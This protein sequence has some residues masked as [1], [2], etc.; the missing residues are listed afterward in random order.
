MIPDS[1][2]NRNYKR[3][4]YESSLLFQLSQALNSSRELSTIIDPVLTSMAENIAL[5]RGTVTI[6]SRITGK[7]SI[8]A[9]VELSRDEIKRGIYELGE[10]ITGKVVQSGRA[11]IIKNI[12]L[13]PLFLNKTGVRQRRKNSSFLCVPIKHDTETIGA[14]SADRIFQDEHGLTDDVQLLAIVASMISRTVKQRQSIEDK[15]KELNGKNKRLNES[16]E[17]EFNPFNMI[18]RSHSMQEAFSL[19]A[20][21]SRS[22]A[23]VFIRGESG[24]GKELVAQT[25][26]YNSLRAGKPFI[27]INCSALPESIIESELF[28]HEKGSFTGAVGSR[29]GRFELADGGSV[30]LDEIGELS[31]VTQVKLLRVLQEREIERVGGNRTIPVDVRIIAATNKDVDEEML[32]GNFREDLYYRLNVFPICIPPLRERRSDIMLLTEHFIEK[33]SR[34]NRTSVKKISS[35]AI[36][37][38]MNY[39]WPGNVRELE[40]CIERAVLLSHDQEIDVSDLPPSLQLAESSPTAPGSTLQAAL[41]GLEQKLLCDALKTTR[42]NMASAARKLAVSERIMGLRVKKYRIDLDK[43]RSQAQIHGRT[44]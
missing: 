14:F 7:I 16:S 38:L 23:T 34:R 6:L 12:S 39:H 22:E 15:K 21:V 28:G 4:I 33:N 41:D 26:H 44:D 36:D 40:N 8:A 3:R 20:Q 42:G 18:G 2:K 9:S 17:E 24:T 37:L 13:E 25:L 27:K 35:S 43:Y 1:Y 19:M 5:R 32:K 10:G 31:P 30:F 29:K 11:E